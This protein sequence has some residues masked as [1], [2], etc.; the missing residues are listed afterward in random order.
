M[1]TAFITD[2][3]VNYE[4]SP[5]IILVENKNQDSYNINQN[6]ADNIIYLSDVLIKLS[7]ENN[8]EPYIEL[9]D[10]QKFFIEEA[11]EK[12]NFVI[13]GDKEYLEAEGVALPNDYV[14]GLT[15]KLISNLA[16]ENI[17]PSN[18]STSIEEGICLSFKKSSKILYF[19]LYNNGELGY[20]IEDAKEKKILENEDLNSINEATDKIKEFFI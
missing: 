20:I 13:I 19:E 6:K 11:I 15:N 1:I 14:I 8:N 18:I 3:A 12:L 16:P 9:N 7:F 17:F 4:R 10:N 5:K 2:Y